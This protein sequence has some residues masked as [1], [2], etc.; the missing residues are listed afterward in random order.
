MG[1]LRPA[2]ETVKCGVHIGIINFI[3]GLEYSPGIR[4]RAGYLLSEPQFLHLSNEAVGRD[5]TM[6]SSHETQKGGF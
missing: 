4:S 3:S 5:I 2:L 1:T 6:G